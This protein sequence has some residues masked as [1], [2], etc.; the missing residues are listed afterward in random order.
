VLSG[1]ITPTPSSGTI[2]FSYPNGN[3]ITTY[4]GSKIVRLKLAGN[5]PLQDYTATFF[6]K[7]PN[8]TPAHQRTATIKVLMSQVLAISVSATPNPVCSGS[9]TQLSAT[10]NGGA[11]PYTYS[12]T[13]NPPGFTSNIA[14]PT[15]TPT[16][17][18]WYKCTVHD[19]VNTIVKDSVFVTLATTPA[20]PG[21]ING[22]T[23]P[24]Q[25][26]SGT[27]S[28]ASVLNATTYT[29]TVPSGASISS[30]QGTTS[31]MVTF[32]VTPGNITVTAGN[33][34]GTSSASSLA[35]TLL[36]LPSPPGNI[37]GPNSVCDNTTQTY[38]VPAVSGITNNWTVPA[39]ASITSGQGTPTI[40]VLWGVNSGDV[41][42][43]AQNSCGYSS[44]TT[45]NVA[46]ETI[47]VAAGTMT[48]PTLLCMGYGGYE[49]TIP[50]ISNAST[51]IWTLPLGLTITQG[52]GTNSITVDVSNSAQS[53]SITAAGSN[54]CGTG[55][56]S[57]LDVFVAICDGIN[58]N[59]LQSKI[60]IYPNPTHG[61]LNIAIKGT[62]KQLRLKIMD[63][64]G[65]I[66]VDENLANL[67]ADF[68]KQV[69]VSGFAKGMYTIKLSN[70][71][72][73]F[74]GKFAVN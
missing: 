20:T 29:W 14:S 18:T 8:G 70:D 41:S 23:T 64:T 46:V 33:A 44:A 32:G 31:I 39:G 48:G 3:K 25:A 34:C 55:T 69:D 54:L 50:P 22:N 17:N 67:P 45:L 37:T 47:P 38:G 21:T 35:V 74:T 11:Q 26:G 71:S 56:A 12:W 2:T 6:A 51:Y 60:E 42:V 62:E 30:G 52:V 59:T 68:S 53:G 49:F 27:Y 15:A 24:C 72:R 57:S 5:V 58:E 65:K 9:S 43:T 4:P 40:T 63:M 36:P 1:T 61:F 16:V 13:S 66:L 19:N 73:T 10:A 28:V 7:G